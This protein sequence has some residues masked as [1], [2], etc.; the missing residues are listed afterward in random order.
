MESYVSL[1]EGSAI[2]GLPLFKLQL[3]LDEGS[4]QFFPSIPDLEQTVVFVIETVSSAMSSVPQIQ[5]T[6]LPPPSTSLTHVLP[7]SLPQGWLSGASPCPT[8]P[9]G[10]E[11]G[12]LKRCEGIVKQALHRNLQGPQQHMAYYGQHTHAHTHAHT[13]IRTHACTHTHTHTQTVI[14]AVLHK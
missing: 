5:V 2:S 4:M 10:V 9:S 3:C 14:P 13:H 11:R 7:P 6:A 12:M 1:Y 8:I